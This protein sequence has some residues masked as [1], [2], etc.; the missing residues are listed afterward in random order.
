MRAPIGVARPAKAG[1]GGKVLKRWLWLTHRWLGIGTCLLMAI[2]FGSGLAMVYFPYPSLAGQEWLSG[3]RPIAW[4][5]VKVEPGAA[6][7][8]GAGPGGKPGD[9][10]VHGAADGAAPRQLSLV[11]RGDQPVWIH[12]GWGHASGGP[13]RQFNATTGAEAGPA[14]EAEARAIARAFS[15]RA[16]IGMEQVLQDQWTVAANYDPHRPL[17]KARLAPSGDDHLYVS[18]VSGA[19]VLDTSGQERIWNWIGT[20]PHWIY[21]TALRQHPEAWRQ[22]V[23]WLSGPA[24]IAAITGIWIGLLRVRLGRRRY[25][26]RA[27][28]PYHGWMKWH[29]VAGLAGAAVLLGWI[30]SGWLSLDPGRLFAS[31]A[32]GTQQQ[33][34]YAGPLEG[35]PSLSRLRAAAAGGDARRITLLGAAG[36]PLLRIESGAGPDLLLDPATLA[37]REDGLARALARAQLLVPQARVREHRL[38]H[39]ADSYWYRLRGPLQLPV[40]RLRLDDDAGTWLHVHP[41]TGEVLGTTNATRRTYRWLFGFLHLWD[42]PVL[43][44]RPL[45]REAWI[46][47]FSL[48]GLVTSISGVWLGW[49]RLRQDSRPRRPAPRLGAG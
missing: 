48:L 25:R 22:V 8:L 37:P 40:W 14:G 36:A 9:G 20:V 27:F 49:K 3:Q 43:L 32:P 1:P 16:V 13:G 12:Q 6:L 31:E 42:A 30:F 5:R 26:N 11:M 4:E 44:E 21:F 24:V 17:W 47:V 33:M 46:W 7:A 29:H 45:L 35:L 19:V 23:L 38:L 2:W 15:G 34:A 10:S 18:S 39:R 41:E 28:T